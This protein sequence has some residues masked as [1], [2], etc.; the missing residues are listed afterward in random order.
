MNPQFSHIRL[1]AS[2]IDGTLLQGG[3]TAI[4]E[5]LF[6]Q[7]RA[8][9]GQGIRFCAASGR[10]HGSLRKLFRPVEKEICYICENGAVVFSPEG[11]VLSR[12]PMERE[13]ALRLSH[14]I[15]EVPQFEVLISG[16]ETSYLIP[17]H[18]EFLDHIRYFVGN[19][20]TLVPSPEAI[21]ED[22]LKVSAYCPDG[23]LQYQD[24]WRKRWGSEVQIAL[25]GSLWLDCGVASK[26]EGI[27]TVC[28][29]TSIDPAD[30]MAFGDNHNDLPMLRTVGHPCL[31]EG[32]PEELRGLPYPKT[33]RPETVIARLLEKM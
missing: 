18:Q 26:R 12:T 31:M 25:G 2:D 10:Q 8:L 14:R 32:A 5:R 9:K 23:A 33:D 3:R 20:V 27:L 17:K 19:D 16:A 1:I 28:Q 4:S 15:L 13:A 29:A 11:E 7:V 22:I 6:T 30:V 21:E 24:D